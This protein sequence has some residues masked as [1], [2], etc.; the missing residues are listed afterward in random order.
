MI[1]LYIMLTQQGQG[2]CQ[3]IAID[4]IYDTLDVSHRITLT[5]VNTT[6]DNFDLTASP[7]PSQF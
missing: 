3:A 5:A 1:V 7:I 6:N 4:S 2:A